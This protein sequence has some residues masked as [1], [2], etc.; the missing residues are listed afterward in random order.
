MKSE[1]GMALKG[2][3][4]PTRGGSPAAASL[5]PRRG[6]AN[7]LDVAPASESMAALLEAMA[8]VAAVSVPLI[9]AGVVDLNLDGHHLS[10]IRVEARR[11]LH[12]LEFQSGPHVV[13][14]GVEALMR[15][16]PSVVASLLKRPGCTSFADAPDCPAHVVADWAR[17]CPIEF[18]PEG[19]ISQRIAAACRNGGADLSDEKPFSLLSKREKM[20]KALL[21]LKVGSDFQ[22]KS[23]ARALGVNRHVLK[24]LCISTVGLPPEE[25]AWEFF[26]ARVQSGVRLQRGESQIAASVGLANA[27]SLNRAYTRRNIPFP[28][29]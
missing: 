5:Q 2:G 21:T 20:R 15:L 22:V 4:R 17:R 12:V 14:L 8:S 6:K 1:D 24:R 23:W 28:I 27:Y 10:A 26:H 29:E 13:V 25:V 3:D 19:E 7:A 16:R 11:L 18:V 9:L